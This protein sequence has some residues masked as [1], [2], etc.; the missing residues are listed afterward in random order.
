MRL[1]DEI[2]Q[3]K[4][5]TQYEKLAVN[6]LFTSSWL[7]GIHQ[8]MLRPHGISPQQ[9]NLLRI[10]RG[11]HPNPASVGLLIDRMIDKMS[12]ASR[13]V[14]KLRQKGLVERTECPS[15]RRRVDVVITD[16]G[17][18][19][20]DDIAADTAG[21]LGMMRTLSADEAQAA[22]D[23]LDKLRDAEIPTT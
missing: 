6:I 17:L 14:E 10:L 23:I 7:S 18:K 22:N 1:E 4:F 13:L 21:F 16:A 11:Q 20:L 19:L 5:A 8:K 3:K 2:K 9:F 15:D 12:N